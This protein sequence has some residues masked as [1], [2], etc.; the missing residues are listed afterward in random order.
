MGSGARALRASQWVK[1]HIVF[2]SCA[3]TLKTVQA[4]RTGNLMWLTRNRAQRHHRGEAI[5]RHTAMVEV[6]TD[7]RIRDVNEPFCAL[8]GYERG[9]LIGKPQTMLFP[10]DYVAGNVFQS[11]WKRV[12][13][14]EFVQGT[15]QQRRRKNGEVLWVQGVYYPIAGSSGRVES[16]VGLVYDVTS[17]AGQ[18]QCAKSVV[19]AIE[20]SMAVIEFDLQGHVLRA[21]D[22]FLKAMGYTSESLVGQHHRILCKPDYVATVQYAK[23]WDDLRAG[24]YFDGQI[25]RVDSRGRT[26]WLEATYNPVLDPDGNVEH[27]IKFATDVTARVL[28]MQARAQGAKT[29][30]E[31]AQETQRLSE[32]GAKTILDATARIQSMAR[33]FE[34][35]SAR[36]QDLGRKTESIVSSVQGI[37]RVADQ[38][39]LLALNAAVEAARAGDAGRGFAVVAEEVRKLAGSSR[40]ATNDIH[41]TIQAVQQEMATMTAHIQGGVAAME[42]GV[43]L[44]RQAGDA[45]ER[46][47][48]DAHKVVDVV[49]E[50]RTLETEARRVG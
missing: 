4:Q 24:Q 43:L 3:P 1:Y 45:I 48:S 9:D 6:G 17:T 8:L 41:Q 44:S 46:I 23:F 32:Q 22:N 28:Q 37:R 12:C 5:D 25:E 13:A 31:V 15:A 50:L 34:E 19:Q 14:G 29:A 26:V 20:R 2:S 40:T 36:V 10:P 49:Q 35:T 21:N 47:R 39:N 16:I 7:G 11:L 18:A 27:V 30:F 33:L 38:T 42:Q